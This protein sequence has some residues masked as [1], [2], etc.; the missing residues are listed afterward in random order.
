MNRAKIGVVTGLQAEARW[1]GKAGFMVRVGGGTPHG[2][3]QAAQALVAEG[4]QAL[5]S[6]GLAGGLKPGLKPGTVLVP[7]VIITA[8]RTYRCDWAL[9][10]FLGGETSGAL[11]A[12]EKIV[13]TAHNK[14]SLFFRFQAVAVDLESGAVAEIATQNA[15]PFAALRAVTDPAERDLPPAS[16]VALKEDGSLAL[17]PLLKS[18]LR[19]PGQ[20]PGL[21]AVGRDAKAARHALRARLK[22][23]LK[24]N[25]PLK[26]FLEWLWGILS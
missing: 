23:I 13:T 18:L 8:R 7:P 16:L 19:Q 6:F 25:N 26:K 17:G 9:T 10:Q 20:I 3:R 21:M 5:L 15:M 24:S 2:A 22:V 4:A 11:L 12:G 14:T 1:L